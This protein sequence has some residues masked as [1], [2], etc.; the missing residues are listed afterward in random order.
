M[1]QSPRMKCYPDV[2]VIRKK[3]SDVGEC[4]WCEVRPRKT[5]QR[6]YIG[7]VLKESHKLGGWEGRKEGEL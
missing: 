7:L 2:K 5:L 1:Q 4:Q 6:A 3:T